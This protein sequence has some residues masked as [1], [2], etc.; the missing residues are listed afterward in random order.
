MSV[1][2]EPWFTTELTFMSPFSKAANLLACNSP[3][4]MPGVPELMA[5]LAR[6]KLVNSFF[7]SLGEM[8]IPVSLTIIFTLLAS[9][10]TLMLIFPPV[11]VYFRALDKRLVS[12]RFNNW[13][14]AHTPSWQSM[15]LVCNVFCC[16]WQR[17]WKTVKRLSMICFSG[18]A[19][20]L[21]S[22]LEW[23]IRSK[24]SSCDNISSNLLRLEC[25]NSMDRVAFSWS[26]ESW[27]SSSRGALIS[28]SG[29]RM[30]WAMLTKKA[31]FSFM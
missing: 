28:V 12:I 16:C 7:C 27:R 31:I 24:S 22:M 19:S 17:G 30:S 2:S 29:V 25:A 23:S 4:P 3:R 21:G 14:S 15:L 13:G 1:N 11:G 5:L 8:P 9:V 6:K 18:T 10:F 20:I 26:V